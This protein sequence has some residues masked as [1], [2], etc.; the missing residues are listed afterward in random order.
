MK[1]LSSVELMVFEKLF[2]MQ[3]GYVLNFSNRTFDQFIFESVGINVRD[4]HYINNVEQ[5][6]YSSS[7]AN[8]LRYFWTNEEYNVVIKLLNDLVEYCELLDDSEIDE[9]LLV[10]AQQILSNHETSPHLIENN[11]T[12]ETISKLIDDI[13]NSIEIGRPQFTL[14]R[15]HTLMGYYVKE[16]CDEHGI[17]YENREDKLNQIFKRYSEFI[18]N[19][20]ES[21]LSKTI[22][23]Q[24]GSIF[25]K[26]NSVRNNQSYA[27]PNPILNEA[28]SLLIYKDVVN[29]FEFIRTIENLNNNN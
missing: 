8:I 21:D 20:L 5:T 22:I 14:D 24:T 10:K 11:S 7:K 1:K 3:S 2:N 26:F 23:M 12:E 9:K 27:H 16:L 19:K 13:N 4:E 6:M 29:V 28:E 25:D 18:G 17:E 15:L